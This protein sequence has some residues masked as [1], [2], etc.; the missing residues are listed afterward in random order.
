MTIR[1]FSK[2]DTY[3]EF[4]NFAPFPIELDGKR[5]PTSEHF[6]QAQKFA[7]RELQKRIRAADKPIIAKN[8]ADKHRDKIRPDWDAV[9]DDVMYRAVRCK[10]ETHAELR[11]LLRA[12]GDEEI[13]EAAPNDYYWGVGSNGTGQN[14]LGLIIER[15][16]RELCGG[17][18]F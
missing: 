4:S 12:T 11:E 9:K 13:V 14:K 15:I 6:Y 17:E 1:F 3:R 7:D 5:W 10:F 18:T 2:S 8:L 16:R